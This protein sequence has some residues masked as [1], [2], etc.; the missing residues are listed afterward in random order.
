MY[1]VGV[2]FYNPFIS[3]SGFSFCAPCYCPI[4]YAL[5]QSPSTLLQ[6]I[7]TT[8]TEIYPSVWFYTIALR[9]TLVCS[10]LGQGLIFVFGNTPAMKNLLSSLEK[11]CSLS[12]SSRS[13]SG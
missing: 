8:D 10:G 3:F 13:I 6:H 11:R 9:A 5:P 4:L 12:H 7:F 1:F 2:L